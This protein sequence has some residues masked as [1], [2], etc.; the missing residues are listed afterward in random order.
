MSPSYKQKQY[1]K[2]LLE[3]PEL[4][5]KDIKEMAGYSENTSPSAIENSNGF[6]AIAERIQQAKILSGFSVE[7]SLRRLQTIVERV[8]PEHD[9][10]AIKAIQ[11][12]TKITGEQMPDVQQLDINTTDDD[13]LSVLSVKMLTKIGS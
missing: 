4:P 3:H 2:G 7:S 12:G 10:N 13:I 5:K 9:G 6:R 8:G 1:A 11:V